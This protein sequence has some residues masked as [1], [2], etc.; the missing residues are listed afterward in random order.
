MQSLTV[1][2]PLCGHS[3]SIESLAALPPSAQATD[4]PATYELEDPVDC[5]ACTPPEE[6][7]DW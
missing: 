1:R 7:P 4:D 5:P 3:F 2:H 6:Q